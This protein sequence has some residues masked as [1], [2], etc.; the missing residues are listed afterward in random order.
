MNQILRLIKIQLSILIILILGRKN[1]THIHI[2]SFLRLSGLEMLL[3]IRWLYY[4]AF[5]ILL[6]FCSS[7]LFSLSL[8]SWGQRKKWTFGRHH[9][10]IIRLI[11]IM[12][13]FVLR[14]N[15]KMKLGISIGQLAQW[16]I[17]HRAVGRVEFLFL[18]E[19]L[20]LPVLYH[21]RELCQNLRLISVVFHSWKPACRIFWAFYIA[22]CSKSGS[23]FLFVLA[24]NI[25]KC[26][27]QFFKYLLL[28]GLKFLY[29]YAVLR[30]IQI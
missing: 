7:V 27:S 14:W 3:N 12:W 28:I 2:S 13:S 29:F 19:F 18:I 24:V 20:Y 5:V 10:A 17:H 21:L 25:N 1:L 30:F 23:F 11:R 9:K 22:S 16:K 6:V 15:L 8:S 4:L 26:L